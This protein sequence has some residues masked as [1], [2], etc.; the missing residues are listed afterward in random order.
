MRLAIFGSCVSRDSIGFDEE[1]KIELLAY[2]ARSSIASAFGNEPK[3][4]PIDTS[5]IKSQ[6]QR[7][8]VDY[9]I[10]KTFRRD[11]SA[12]DFDYLLMD[13]IDERFNIWRSPEGGLLTLSNEFMS[14]KHELNGGKLIQ[15][16]S[17]EW[18][19]YWEIAWSS[20]YELMKENGL[21]NKIII[22][23][24]YWSEYMASGCNTIPNYPNTLIK[25][26]NEVLTKLYEIIRKDLPDSAF[27]RFSQ[28]ELIA[29]NDHQWGVSPFHYID[30]YYKKI[31][32]SLYKRERSDI[33]SNALSSDF[34]S[35]RFNE[36][37]IAVSYDGNL[38]DSI[39]SA[40]YFLIN[41]NRWDIKH[42]SNTHSFQ[43]NIPDEFTK[44]VD[45]IEV[46]YFLRDSYDNRASLRL[47]V[48]E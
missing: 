13:F 24:S 20:F 15:S 16:G 3:D 28:C 25:R 1:D 6:F 32:N 17:I 36:N 11:I 19:R 30:E 18:L 42:Y 2:F 5:V 29:K 43:I 14:S 35:V 38:P 26:S 27:I 23:E 41:N 44:G 46:I 40:C 7:R 33:L 31:I 45:T 9:D 48:E 39:V 34:I 4:T 37:N 10:N 22:S 47:N 8:I 12:L 21:Q